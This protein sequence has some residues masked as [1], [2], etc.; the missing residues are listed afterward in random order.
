ML[1]YPPYEL[2]FDFVPR[3]SL[4]I[5]RYAVKRKVTV[6]D[7]EEVAANWFEAYKYSL[8]LTADENVP[9]LHR[10]SE[11]ARVVYITFKKIGDEAKEE[12]IYKECGKKGLQREEAK[13]GLQELHRGGY[14]YSP[15]IELYHVVK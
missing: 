11:N 10:L 12:E 15:R 7:V 6:K 1:G 8:K 5:G 3:L 14:V 9:N 2:D 13:K 4:T